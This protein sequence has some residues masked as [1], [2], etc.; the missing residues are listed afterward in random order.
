MRVSLKELIPE[1]T[2]E[3]LDKRMTDAGDDDPRNDAAAV[4]YGYSVWMEPSTNRAWKQTDLHQATATKAVEFLTGLIEKLEKDK[5][6]PLIVTS[7]EW[8]DKEI[9]KVKQSIDQYDKKMWR[10]LGKRA[11]FLLLYQGT[12]KALMGALKIDKVTATALYNGFEES[13]P[14][15]KAYAKAITYQ[16]KRKGYCENPFGRRYFLSDPSQFYC[17][18]N[19]M[20]QGTCAYDLKSKMVR[21]DNYLMS[22][23]AKTRMVLCVH[24]E[25]IFSK[26]PGEEHHIQHCVDIMED[27]SMLNI[28]LVSEKETTTTF[29]SDKKAA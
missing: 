17:I 24:D 9:L 18:A 12:V 21:I 14:Q 26:V 28:P 22:S 8:F 2:W 23:G 15:L 5:A 11:N 16:M 29:W 1:F 27:S 6:D 19:Y 4:K 3:L 20:I 10:Q 7:D 13:F 25:I